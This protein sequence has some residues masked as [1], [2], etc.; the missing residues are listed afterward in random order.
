[1]GSWQFTNVNILGRDR[2]KSI[3]TDVSHWQIEC[4]KLAQDNLPFEI[5]GV[6]T[7]Q[8]AKFCEELAAAYKFQT[9]KTD[10]GFVFTPTIPS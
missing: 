10:A 5:Y 2:I 6:N 4:W 9:V 7:S 8:H 1:M 3:S